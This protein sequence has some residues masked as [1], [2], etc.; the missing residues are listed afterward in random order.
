LKEGVTL[1]SD[2]S[3]KSLRNQDMTTG[4]IIKKML[5]FAVPVVLGNIF[6]Q[7]YGAVDTAV[8]GRYVGKTALAAVGSSSSIMMVF[9]TVM[10]GMNTG[11]G[12]VVSQY[13]GSKNYKELSKTITSL[14]IVATM[15]CI[16][17]M[18]LGSVL[19]VPMLKLLN[20]PE[21]LIPQASLY[22]RIVFIG[23]LGQFYYFVGT[24]ILNGMGDSKLPMYMVILSSVINIAL[25][26]VFVICFNWDVA[27]V[28]AATA[29]AQA[30]SAAVV[31]VK[32]FRYEILDFS[33]VNWRIDRDKIRAIFAIGIPTSI[34]SLAMSVGSMVIQ[35]FSNSFGTDFIAAMTAVN[36]VDMFA[37]MPLHSL[38]SALT[39]FV[40]QNVG[41]GL[42]DRVKEGVRKITIVIV[43]AG[44]AIGG[45]MALFGGYVLKIF[46]TE[47]TVLSIGMVCMR[48]AATSYW[49]Q[50]L[51]QAYSGLL[52]GSGVA[53][54]PA[55]IMIAA[56]CVRI[57][58]TYILAGVNGMYQGIFIALAAGNILGG[59]AMV[60]YYASGH[61]KG[62]NAIKL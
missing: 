62:K 11:A 9:H 21:E 58:I 24:F 7:L 19:S 23:T 8:V 38:G 4:S 51:Q 3:S 27:G 1:L 56:L 42:H 13:F 14:L 47:A 57:L 30:V 28:A 43:V 39:T 37:I 40:G 31:L 16:A 52:R 53:R 5:L 26:L 59:L 6:S 22:L 45:I 2:R 29:I 44:L 61:W 35:R 49:G 48:I 17:M 33:K 15:V 55:I 36:K 41:A 25:D 18:V 50:S 20:T 60:A 46:V 12:V 10:I 32:I 34:Q 54:V